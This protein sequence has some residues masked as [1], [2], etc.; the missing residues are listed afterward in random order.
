[1]KLVT[2][3]TGRFSTLMRHPILGRIAARLTK[4]EH[5]ECLQFILDHGEMA[6]LD[7]EHEINRMFIDRPQKPRHWTEMSELLMASNI[8]GVREE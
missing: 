5:H 3:R 4:E 6:H 8:L 2:E 1:M 7:F